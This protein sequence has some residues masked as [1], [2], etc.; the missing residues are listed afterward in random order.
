MTG[1]TLQS[2]AVELLRRPTESPYYD[3]VLAV[4]GPQFVTWQID[5][6]GVTRL[7][8]YYGDDL[9]GALNDFNARM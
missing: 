6:H 2:G 7:G 9:Q 4:Y 8:N 3:I 5:R 1:E